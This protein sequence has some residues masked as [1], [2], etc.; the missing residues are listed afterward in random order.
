MVGTYVSGFILWR[1]PVSCFDDLFNMHDLSFSPQEMGTC[2]PSKEMCHEELLVLYVLSRN[3]LQSCKIYALTGELE[4]TIS[5][6]I[7]RIFLYPRQYVGINYYLVQVLSLASP[8]PVTSPSSQDS[9]WYSVYSYH[10]LLPLG[11]L[12][13]LSSPGRPQEPGQEPSSHTAY[14]RQSPSRPP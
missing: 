13:R 12:H 4:T 7:T 6:S 2:V 1:G 10:S 14:Q 11:A 8:D 5:L 3:P 9:P